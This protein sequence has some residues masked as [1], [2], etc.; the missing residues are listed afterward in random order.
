MKTILKRSQTT[1]MASTLSLLQADCRR[2][3]AGY[4]LVATSIFPHCQ[5]VLDLKAR[6]KVLRMKNVLKFRHFS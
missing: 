4:R 5:I 1:L 3:Q 6:R 2:K